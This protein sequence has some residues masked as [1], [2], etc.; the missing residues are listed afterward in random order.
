MTFTCNLAIISIYF[1]T[2]STGM[3]LSLRNRLAPNQSKRRYVKSAFRA[4]NAFHGK[5]MWDCA[6]FAL[7]GLDGNVK[8]F[9]G[10]ASPF[11]AMQSVTIALPLGG[12]RL[13]MG[14]VMLSIL[15]CKCLACRRRAME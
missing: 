2:K 12:L 10:G 4:M 8:I 9:L 6:K 14:I 13:A 1:I 11:F 3:S 5:A 15:L 7:E